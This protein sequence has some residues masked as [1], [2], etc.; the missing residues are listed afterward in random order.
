MKVGEE[1]PA[2]R[3]VIAVGK[4]TLVSLYLMVGHHQLMR[5][6]CYTDFALSSGV[7]DEAGKL[8]KLNTALCDW[9]VVDSF[10]Q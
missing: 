5:M 10:Q 7:P 3:G 4:G 6:F 9:V 8:T 1:L 2:A